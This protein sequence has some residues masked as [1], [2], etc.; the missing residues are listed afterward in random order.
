MTIPETIDA[1]RARFGGAT[2]LAHSFDEPAYRVVVA[3]G[4]ENDV[5]GFE[6]EKN[7]QV[8]AG[9]QFEESSEGADAEAAM[10]VRMAEGLRKFR[11][12]FVDGGSLV[13]GESPEGARV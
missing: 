11:D 10:L 13:F 4:H 5:A 7:A 2:N 1:L 9:A 8:Q 3:D 6:R 12:G